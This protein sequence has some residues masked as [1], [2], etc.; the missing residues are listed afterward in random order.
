VS[1]INLK[2]LT[3]LAWS[4]GLA[5]LLAAMLGAATVWLSLR[6]QQDEQKVRHTLVVQNH[7]A[8]IL[9]LIQHVETNQRGYLLTGRG[10]YLDAYKHAEKTLLA[11]MDEASRLVADNPQQHE[12]VAFCS[13][14]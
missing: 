4:L 14:S 8:R 5:A 2:P 6:I 9:G 3:V 11:V 7:V 13:R 12:T 1:P 10:I